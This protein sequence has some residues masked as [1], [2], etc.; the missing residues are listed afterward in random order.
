M[1]EERR[2]QIRK[3]APPAPHRTN[4]NVRYSHCGKPSA[5]LAQKSARQDLLEKAPEQ[6]ERERE[7]DPLLLFTPPLFLSSDDFFLSRGLKQLVQSKQ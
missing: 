2:P 1:T 7:G 5:V 3:F 4:V 6:R